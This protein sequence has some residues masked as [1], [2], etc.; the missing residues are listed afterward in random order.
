LKKEFSSA[1]VI[2]GLSH[3]QVALFKTFHDT[4]QNLC[5]TDYQPCRLQDKTSSATT[6]Q[7]TIAL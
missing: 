3:D 6:M 5:K 2:I 1:K 4:V 7:L